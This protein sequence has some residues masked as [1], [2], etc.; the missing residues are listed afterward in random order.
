MEKKFDVLVVDDDT[1]LS[2]NLQDILEAEGYNIGIAS[3]GE[4]A[5]TLC[6]EKA[7]DLAI[8]DINLPDISGIDLILELIG[9]S[10]G[11]TFIIITGFASLDSVIKA[12]GQRNIAA[13]VTKPVNIDN[14][15]ALVEFQRES[16]S[17]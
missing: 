11:M 8:V 5:F 16:A 4:T 9:W 2:S 1:N 7:F 14:L 10:P 3:N 15:L 6:R 12:S 17:R 13:Y